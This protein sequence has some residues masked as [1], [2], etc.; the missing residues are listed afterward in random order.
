[1]KTQQHAHLWWGSQ[2]SSLSGA[3]IR[4]G[5][6]KLLLHIRSPP[7]PQVKASEET[8]TP[9]PSVTA[10]PGPRISLRSSCRAKPPGA[11]PWRCPDPRHTR[12]ELR[13]GRALR[14]PRR[15]GAPA[16][17]NGLKGRTPR[18]A[19]GPA[20]FPRAPR[21]RPLSPLSP[22]RVPLKHEGPSNPSTPCRSHWGHE[23]REHG[24]GRQL[25]PPPRGRQ[26]GAGGGRVPGR[27]LSPKAAPPSAPRITTADYGPRAGRRHVQ[28][29]AETSPGKQRGPKAATSGRDTRTPRPSLPTLSLGARVDTASCHSCYRL[30]PP[31]PKRP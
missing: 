10:R 13:P 29:D 5:H 25:S 23:G 3:T 1:M 15:P 2:T 12:R 17:L 14:C 21:G 11:A 22:A 9:F 19:G 24:A 30:R 27:V 31:F 18:D 6:G 4:K 8:R 16:G 28:G 26:P 20:R 7:A